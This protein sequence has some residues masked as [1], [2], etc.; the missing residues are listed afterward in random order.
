MIYCLALIGFLLQIAFIRV[1]KKGNMKLALILKTV[2]AVVFVMVGLL[3][4]LHTKNPQHGWIV[5]CGLS[6]CAVGDFLLNY[7][8]LKEN[9]EPWFVAG[10]FANL[11]GHVLFISSLLP[12]D[13]T[14]LQKTLLICGVLAVLLNIYIHVSIKAGLGLRIFGIVYITA[15]IFIT[16]HTGVM[17]YFNPA[18]TG[19]LIMSI[20]AGLFTF[21]DVL[22]IFD[23]FGN[24]KEWMRAADLVTYYLGQ[25]FI[26]YSV[27]WFI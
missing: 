17:Y 9:P 22:L 11:V 5:V 1:E 14:Q 8:F 26:A 24:K 23:A 6:C 2:A 15:L 20:G 4:V 25:L 19:A 21:S 3:S 16:V 13:G 12:F 10:A 18:N 27:F 7:Q